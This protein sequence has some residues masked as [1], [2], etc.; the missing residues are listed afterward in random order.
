[1]PV[2]IPDNRLEVIKMLISRV[3]ASFVSLDL[4]ELLNRLAQVERLQPSD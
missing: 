4:A 2:D 3:D 1:M